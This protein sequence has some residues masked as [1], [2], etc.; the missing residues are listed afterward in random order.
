MDA[1]A[2]AKRYEKLAFL[3]EGQFATVF[4]A[5]DKNNN[6]IVAIKKI[7]LGHRSEA[8]DGI[9]RT[10]L[11]EIKLLQELSHPNIIGLLDAFGHKSNISLVFDF[12][13]TDL[14][15]IIKDTSIVLT[16]SHIKA[17][18][19]MTLQGL[20]YLHQHWI[21]HRDLKPNNLLLDENGI[22]K[23]ADFGLAKSFGSPNRVYTHQVVTR[24]YRAPELLFGAK[25]YGVG[26]DMWAV[27]CILAEL[28]LRGMTSLPD[29]VT[30]KSFPGMPLQHIF[31]AA[32]DDLLSLLQGLFT[33]NPCT[34]VTA[35]QAL[36][37]KYFSN[38]PGPTPG[39]QLPRPNCPAEA[40]KEEQSKLSNLKRKKKEGIVQG[41]PKKLIF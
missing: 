16:Q 35:T 21:L 14:E 15:V 18:M 10:A 19:L 36:K 1:R 26:V 31:S 41:L 40:I 34:R 24:W 6:Q 5:R 25:M 37:Q 17:Y 27:G 8:K 32:G 29:Y 2:R 12:M 22:L 7:K 9:N 3:G 4:K 20:E 11:R 28:L 30:F 38:R 33:F 23:L 13:E 39:N